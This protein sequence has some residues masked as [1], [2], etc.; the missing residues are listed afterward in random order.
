MGNTIFNNIN[1]SKRGIIE[2]TG[3]AVVAVELQIGDTVRIQTERS[4]YMRSGKESCFT[5]AKL[6]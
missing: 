1:P 5:I 4:M 2:N 3:T 6:N